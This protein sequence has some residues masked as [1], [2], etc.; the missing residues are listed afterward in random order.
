MQFDYNSDHPAVDPQ[1]GQPCSTFA[2]QPIDFP[3]AQPIPCARITTRVF[4]P[5]RNQVATVQ[6]VLV[7]T[8]SSSSS[9]TPIMQNHNNNSYNANQPNQDND[10]WSSSSSS[11]M[12]SMSAA[13]DTDMD[14]D[15]NADEGYDHNEYE[16]YRRIHSTS[17]N[18]I[19]N[20][21]LRWNWQGLLDSTNRARGHLW[22]SLI[23]HRIAKTDRHIGGQPMI[24]RNGKLPINF[25]PL[26]KCHGNTYGKNDID[27]PKIRLRKYLQC[28]SWRHGMIK[29]TNI[30]HHYPQ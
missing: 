25:V 18:S 23:S 4:H 1:S 8:I 21:T 17:C 30:R 9:A 2:A 15:G 19:N 24:M 7:K 28:N 11:D 29:R 10:S 6:N 27:W 5:Q 14:M 16:Y 3:E 26:R 22:T 13:D 20:S 12:S